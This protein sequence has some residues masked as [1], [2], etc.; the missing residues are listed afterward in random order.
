MNAEQLIIRKSRWRLYL[1]VFTLLICTAGLFTSFGKNE[2]SCYLQRPIF[3]LL[4]AALF[5]TFIIY[6]VWLLV[7]RNPEI[8]LSGDGIG[9]CDKGY[10]TWD[11]MDAIGTMGSHDSDNEYIVIYFKEFTPVK[12]NIDDLDKDRKQIVALVLQ[13]ASH[14]GISYK[15]HAAG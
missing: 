14:Q 3:T 12:Y 4:L 8:T 9:L 10:F 7:K 6:N 15:G 13:Y 11:M 5:I 1:Y 2:A